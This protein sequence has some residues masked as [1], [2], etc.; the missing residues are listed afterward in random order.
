VAA[1]AA[2]EIVKQCGKK[3]K[4]NLMNWSRVSGVAV[5]F[6]GVMALGCVEHE[7]HHHYHEE[8]VE[9]S[10]PSGAAVIVEAPPADRYEQVPEHRPGYV[11][12][13]GH[14]LHDGHHYYWTEG[15]WEHVPHE[16]A[17]WVPGHWA[18]GHGGYFW[19]EG[20]WR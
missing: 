16:G 20:N 12:V 5:V 15:H 18:H 19:V 13:R 8:V 6:A 7:H 9:E 4:E 17:E 2:G 3:P 10:A 1:L 14:Y 11:W